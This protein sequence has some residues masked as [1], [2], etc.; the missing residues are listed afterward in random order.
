M[1]SIKAS[2]SE[3]AALRSKIT[4]LRISNKSDDEKR[5]EYQNRIV[6]LRDAMSEMYS[7]KAKIDEEEAVESRKLTHL[8]EMEKANSLEVYSEGIHFLKVLS[9]NSFIFF[10]T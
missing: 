9:V 10:F 2:Y 5:V 6:E 7:K 4:S 3:A 8:L 1:K